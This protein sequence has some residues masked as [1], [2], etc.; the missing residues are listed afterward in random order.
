MA[1]NVQFIIFWSVLLRYLREVPCLHSASIFS[2]VSTH[3]PIYCL[4]IAPYL[5]L[6]SVSYCQCGEPGKATASR[7][8]NHISILGRGRVPKYPDGLWGPPSLQQITGALH[9]GVNRSSPLIHLVPSLRMDGAV[10][11]PSLCAF[12]A[13]RDAATLLVLIV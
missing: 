11:L 12:M 8:K 6:C 9:P 10:P 5:T 7:L 3:F 2:V 4:L 1:P 13:W